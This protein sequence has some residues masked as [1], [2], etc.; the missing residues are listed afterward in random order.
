MALYHLTAR[1]RRSVVHPEAF[2]TPLDKVLEWNRIYGRAGLT[3][4]QCVFPYSAGPDAPRR[5]LDLLRRVGATVYLCVIKDCGPEGRGTLS[6]PMP[7]VSLALDLKVDERTQRI[8]DL[9]NEFVIEAG[10][11]IY[12]TKDRFTRPEHFRA[13]EPRLD[14]FLAVRRRWDPDRRLRSA[15]SVRLLGDPG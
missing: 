1:N 5:F 13:M 6:F 8:V 3:Q 11:R 10:G 12:L 9:A 7:G 15:Q 4:Y 14:E 2:F